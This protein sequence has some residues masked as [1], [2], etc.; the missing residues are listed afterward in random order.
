M[1]KSKLQKGKKF[2]KKRFKKESL[3]IKSEKIANWRLKVPRDKRHKAGE[4]IIIK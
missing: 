4:V 3:I 1:I 2:F